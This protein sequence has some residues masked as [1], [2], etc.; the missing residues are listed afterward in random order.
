MSRSYSGGEITFDDSGLEDFEKMLQQY[1]R[2]A[3]PQNVLDAEEAGAKEFVSDLLKLPK[4]RSEVRKAGYTHLVNTFAM[5][6]VNGEIKVGWGKYYG[7][8][9]EHGTKKM[10][11]KAHLKPLFERNKEKYYRKMTEKIFS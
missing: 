8:M 7:P 2:Q 1:A 3:D 10:T 6:R 11:A 9:V 5:E 4:P